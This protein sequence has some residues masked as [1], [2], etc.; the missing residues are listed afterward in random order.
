MNVC[1]R[2]YLSTYLTQ[3]EAQMLLVNGSDIADTISNLVA[4][5]QIQIL[6]VGNPTSRSAFTR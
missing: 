1:W 5:Y 3:V 4:Q 6:V 2:I